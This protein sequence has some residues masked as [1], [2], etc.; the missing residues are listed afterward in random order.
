MVRPPCCDK[1][2]VK[3][4]LWTAEEDAKILAY[5]ANHGIGNW[6]LVPKKAGLNRCGKSCRLRWTNY[7][8]PDLN[9]NSFTAQ[10]EEL[11]VHLHRAIGSRWSL[12]ARE[13][14]GRTDN[15]VK[16]YWNTKLRKKLFK[17]GIDPVTH[18]PISQIL[19]DYGNISGLNSNL[20]NRI[21]SLNKNFNNP[22]IS[23]SE[24]S[25]VIT[26]PGSSA[27]MVMKPM[28]ITEQLQV[29]PFSPNPSWD[30]LAH[31]SQVDAIQASFFNDLS[32]SSSSSSSSSSSIVTQLSSSQPLSTSEPPLV[33]AT[34]SS[35]SSWC[36]FLLGDPFLSAEPEQQNECNFHGVFPSSSPS[37]LVQNEVPNTNFTSDGNMVKFRGMGHKGSG[38]SD[39]I[40]TT[41]RGETNND[42]ETSSSL[43]SSFVEAILDR[44]SKMQMEFPEV[45]MDESFHF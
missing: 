5:I 37:V 24:P 21:G 15:D 42:F 28:L 11:I 22:L 12:I 2:N 13:L 7:L 10:E 27:T 26:G 43:E 20:Q 41:L 19:S 35:P 18:K 44:H 25:P 9:H 17:M 6:T 31:N 33:L 45:L 30:L 3:R 23:K 1:S 16:N 4:G 32:P 8:R 14:P 39:K 36:E 34:P 40:E 38:A 29:D